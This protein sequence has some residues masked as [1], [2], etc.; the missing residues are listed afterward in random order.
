MRRPRLLTRQIS[1]R[2]TRAEHAALTRI[3]AAENTSV[4]ELVR[5][6]LTAHAIGDQQQPRLWDDETE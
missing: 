5:T 3:A 1:V 6:V 4:S 2:V